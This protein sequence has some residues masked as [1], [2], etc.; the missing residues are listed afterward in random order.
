M[1]RS[2]LCRCERGLVPR[3]SPYEERSSRRE[4]LGLREP[5]YTK[6]PEFVVELDH[7]TVVSYAH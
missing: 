2:A 4:S 7:A 6:C 5:A 1:K 3:V